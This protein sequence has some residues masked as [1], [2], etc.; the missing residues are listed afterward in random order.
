M[1]AGRERAGGAERAD[2]IVAIDLLVDAEQH[3]AEHDQDA[4]AG[5]QPRGEAR[6]GEQVRS[7]LAAAVERDPLGIDHLVEHLF[8][9][10][11]R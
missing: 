5:E 10:A 6:I 3:R 2:A 7:G 8:Q 9:P 4:E 11:A 1:D